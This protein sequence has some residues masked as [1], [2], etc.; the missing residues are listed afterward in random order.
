MV[1][2]S[3]AGQKLTFKK[4]V[5]LSAGKVQ[6][7]DLAEIEGFSTEAKKLVSEIVL[8]DEIK[9]GELRK[10]SAQAI[11]DVLR[12]NIP[13][14]ILGYVNQK[15][16]SDKELKALIKKENQKFCAD[17]SFDFEH[18]SLPKVKY[19]KISRWTIEKPKDLIKGSFRLAL[20]VQRHE[21]QRPQTYYVT[22]RLSSYK[23]LP[24]ARRNLSRGA[25]IMKDDV[26]FEKRPWNFARKDIPTEKE[27]FGGK[28]KRMALSGGVIW[29][30]NIEKEKAIERGQLVDLVVK[31]SDWEIRMKG[32]AQESGMVGDT[33]SVLNR[34]SK[35]VV[36]GKVIGTKEVAVQ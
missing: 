17:C 20:K 15:E 11:T 1:V 26:I 22:G 34:K 13:K 12:R 35:K 30:S 9:E 31:K 4:E 32:V 24:I 8:I 29:L 3:F 28:L 23:K 33:V 21:E 18:F 25:R 27:L 16:W 36:M 14:I 19:D 7:S 5:S 10:L 6:L 2:P